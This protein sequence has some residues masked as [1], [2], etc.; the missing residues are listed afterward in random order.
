M[1]RF[2][3]TAP[4]LAALTNAPP[5]RPGASARAVQSDAARSPL[6]DAAGANALTGTYRETESRDEE[7]GRKVLAATAHLEDD[8]RARQGRALMRILRAAPLFSVEQYGTTF[9]LNYP[10]GA[11]VPYEADGRERPFRA[12]GGETVNVRADLEGDKLTVDITWSGGE[13]LRLCYGRAGGSDRLVFTR[14]AGNRYLPAPVT[15]ES[16]FERV[17]PKA[18]RSFKP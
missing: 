2:L 4:L 12:T 10:D 18:T 6:S 7:I 16:V 5:A 15:V 8:E 3:I 14:T 9:V 1:K 17:S 13:R 11:R